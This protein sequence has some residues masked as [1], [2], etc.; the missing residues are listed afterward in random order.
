LNKNI[1]LEAYFKA[2]S[3]KYKVIEEDKPPLFLNLLNY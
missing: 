3:F 1:I 2:I